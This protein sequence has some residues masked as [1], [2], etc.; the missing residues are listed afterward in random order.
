VD[1]KEPEIDARQ[2]DFIVP[3]CWSSP[4][5]KGEATLGRSFG[6]FLYSFQGQNRTT[7]TGHNIIGR[8][9]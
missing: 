1:H 9:V 7:A 3:V 5:P 8:T 2:E 6:E 4:A